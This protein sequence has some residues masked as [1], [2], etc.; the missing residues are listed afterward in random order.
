MYELLV[1]R[2]L[3]NPSAA[4]RWTYED[5]HLAQMLEVTEQKQFPLS[6]I[7]DAGQRDEY[8]NDRGTTGWN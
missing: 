8:F 6:L 3:F 7:L 5:D 4:S 1:G 2:H